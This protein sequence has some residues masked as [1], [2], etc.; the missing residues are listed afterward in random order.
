LAIAEFDAFLADHAGHAWAADAL[1]YAAEAE[2][3]QGDYEN[4]AERLERFVREH[5]RHRFAAQA[6]FRRGECDYF[7]GDREAAR[8][9]FERFVKDYPR[10]DLLEFALPYLGELSLSAGDPKQAQTHYQRALEKFPAG[11]MAAQCRFGLAQAFAEQGE[12]AQAE[13]FFR[14]VASDTNHPACAE[15]KLRLGAVLISAR[16][17]DEAN[18]WLREV[19]GD[20]SAGQWHGEANFLL[21]QSRHA[22]GQWPEVAAIYRRAYAGVTDAPHIQQARMLSAQALV[23]LG[24]RSI[25]RRIYRRAIENGTDA[26]L[27]NDALV[28]L[29]RLELA[30]ANLTAAREAIAQLAA[31]AESDKRL[32]A[33]EKM[34]L[35]REL[36]AGRYDGAGAYLA[37]VRTDRLEPESTYFA[38]LIALGREQYRE[39]LASFDSLPEHELSHSTSLSLRVARASALLPL[40]RYAEAVAPLESY[41]A[42]APTGREH[43]AVALAELSRW[44]KADRTHA[45]LSP[46]DSDRYY[47]VTL[48]LADKAL[49][50][51]QHA[52][53][54]RYYRI[55]AD[56][57]DR[58]D[59][60][61]SERALAALAFLD[62]N[63]S[64]Q[65]GSAALAQLLARHGDSSVTATALLDA[66][67]SA[68]AAGDEAEALAKFHLL[69]DRFPATEHAAESLLAAGMIY[70]RL[71]QPREAETMWLSLLEH[72]HGAAY[73]D[74]AR[75]NLA[76]AL[77]AQD[78]QRAAH[79]QFER[80][81]RLHTTSQ[82]WADATLRLAS[83]SHAEGRQREA[84]AYLDAVMSRELSP[85]HAA[86][87]HYLRG[88][89]AADAEAWP[90]VAAAM[91]QVLSNDAAAGL[92]RP[93][94]YWLGEAL[95]QLR[96]FQRAEEV[97]TA[98]AADAPSGQPW[99]AMIALR[100]AQC[101][102]HR[103]EWSE[104]RRIAASLAGRFPEF[105][106]QYEA[107][108]LLGR[109]LA[110][111]A[112]FDEARAAYQRVVDSPLAAG[113]ETASMA[114]WMIG[115][116]YFH[117]KQYSEA[118]R[119]YY[120]TAQF[121]PSPVWRAAAMLQAGKC[122]EVRGEWAKAAQRYD[123]LL[124][125]SPATRFH[126]EAQR[127]AADAQRR[128]SVATEST[129]RTR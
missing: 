1:F 10:H 66:A 3:Q 77:I 43:L 24:D 18:G 114:S 51:E 57:G 47:A 112:Q 107:E 42:E 65:Q 20:Q 34:W 69:L 75:Y 39:A 81:H 73:Q 49:A 121:S 104:A 80:L 82:Y 92:Q 38:G 32:P 99:E 86:H 52:R 55:V 54:R 78:Q 31:R 17:H 14:Y 12:A 2:I 110:A 26:N 122:H 46:N 125:I 63:D 72:P 29:A 13:R 62:R 30:D 37:T 93:A 61:Q 126:A 74:T 113:T 120:R 6:V 53:A 117:Q 76:W 40:Q 21:L 5:P 15:A 91:Q 100:R 68:A 85:E 27:H 106:K 128:A 28:G 16:R 19:I 23:E 79:E 11:R 111:Q 115:E 90:A 35:S 59:T 45:A 9:A 44:D 8:A 4:G 60:R 94:S 48:R 25:A 88:A 124:A 89:I 123:E 95:F 96:D 102:A 105:S 97:F 109:S 119:A 36:A 33:L 101:L 41:L 64:T 118:L 83:H 87:A 7:S 67:R 84:N 103:K 50:G 98:L 116:T 58:V 22:R 127:R 70:D 108:Y 71:G 56:A 129:K